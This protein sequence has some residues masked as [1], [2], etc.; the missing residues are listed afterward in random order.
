MS[1]F[2]APLASATVVF[3]FNTD[4]DFEQWTTLNVTD[5]TVAGGTINGTASS[6]DPQLKYE[7][8]LV[9]GAG[10]SWTTV[11]YRVRETDSVSGL[12]IGSAGAPAFSPVGLVVQANGVIVSSG[13]TTVPSGDDFYTIT[14]DISAI[15]DVDITTIRV[16]P[17]GGALSN[18]G[19]ETTGNTFEV[20]FIQVNS[21]PEPSAALLG[22]MA[23]LLLL[24]RRR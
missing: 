5:A 16:D 10:E 21:V 4:G 9:L 18:S 7:Q 22:G 13:F 15:P 12:Y 23:G 17:I 8:T 19:S 11:V 2:L 6:N 24:R 3:G 20:D 14:A 1:S